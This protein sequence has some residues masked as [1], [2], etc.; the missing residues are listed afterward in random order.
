M[1]EKSAAKPGTSHPKASKP[2]TLIV[3]YS[4]TSRTKRVA[5]DLAKRL[6]ADIEAIVD[7]QPR[8][9]G[10][11]GYMNCG[12]QASFRVAS[13][14]QD[15]SRNP[16]NYEKVVVLTPVWSWKMT[17]PVRTWLRLMKGK[18]RAAVFVTV[19]GNTEPEKI[20]AEMADESGIQPLA[21][22]SFVQ[23]D[24]APENRET[25]E[26]KLSKIIDAVK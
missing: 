1:K 22:V 7:K 6:G 23:A 20:A 18:L 3:Y 14:I 4:R 25:H 26:G 13:A 21:V 9:K 15:P 12:R 19:S 16:A 17:P 10:F 8:S 11:F 5:E 24:F 2:K